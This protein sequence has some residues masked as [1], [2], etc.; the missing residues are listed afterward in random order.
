MFHSDIVVHAQDKEVANGGQPPRILSLD[1]YF[2]NEVEK[3]EKDPD[4]GRRWVF[5]LQLCELKVTAPC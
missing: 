5:A 2:I 3:V 4:T 1:A